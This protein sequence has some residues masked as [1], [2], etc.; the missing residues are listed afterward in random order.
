MLYEVITTYGAFTPSLFVPSFYMAEEAGAYYG[1]DGTIKLTQ[2]NIVYSKSIVPFA[3]SV[4]SRNC[5]LM[6]I[7][8][9]TAGNQVIFTD[10]KYFV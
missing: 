2:Y 9:N 7:I 5:A 1:E 3:V 10:S 8:D 6:R 4:A